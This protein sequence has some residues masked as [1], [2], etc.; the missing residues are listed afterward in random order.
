MYKLNL[1]IKYPD[2]FKKENE[3]MI[4]Q[5]VL[6]FKTNNI[7]EEIINE[8]IENNKYNEFNVTINN[9][10][11]ALGEF[12]DK[13]YGNGAP[14]EVRRIYAKIV[15]KLY[16]VEEE[17]KEIELS[18]EQ[19]NFLFETFSGELKNGTAY[20]YIFEELERLKFENKNEK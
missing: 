13:K 5:K 8:Y 11:V 1:D 2:Y 19:F 3:K 12:F 14:L 6:H 20:I 4:K 17:K 16:K 18:D 7:K 9:I 10:F 15:E